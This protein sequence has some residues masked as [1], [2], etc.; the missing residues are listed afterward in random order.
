MVGVAELSQGTNLGES[1][2]EIRFFILVLCP[3]NVKGKGW[4]K[5]LNSI[6]SHPSFNSSFLQSIWQFW[7]RYKFE[8]TF[9]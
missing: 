9:F 8:K 2:Q 1:A 5:H 4:M 7:F 6:S 3:G